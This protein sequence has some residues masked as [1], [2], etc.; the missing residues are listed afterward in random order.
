MKHKF[1]PC[2]VCGENDFEKIF[3]RGVFS[4]KIYVSICKN[5][6]LVCQ[7]PR[8]DE[9]FFVNYYKGSEYYGSHQPR[10]NESAE[11]HN[12]SGRP[13]KIFF[14]VRQKISK[15]SA[16]L[17]VGAG[18][19]ENLFFLKKMGFNNLS[20]T[21]LSKHS[22]DLLNARGIRCYYGTLDNFLL[23]E[24]RKYNLIILSHVLEHQVQPEKMLAQLGGLLK[25]NG[26]VLILVPNLLFPKNTFS[27]F[28]I[29]HVF[30]FTPTSLKNLLSTLR[31]INI[32][33]PKTTSAE[34]LFLSK[35]R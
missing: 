20:A 10:L 19:G 18:R 1:Y 13:K 14:N 24:K 21:E 17:E 9:N 28:M 32:K 27:Q 6:G 15:Q 30:Y 25:K 5:C 7:N 3:E 34:L 29:P 31:Y 23:T 26:L 2:P 33:E 12:S 16:I 11:G 4:D 35:L 8:M 22:S